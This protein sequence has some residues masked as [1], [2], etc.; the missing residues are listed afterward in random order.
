MK[1]IFSLGTVL[2]FFLLGASC[3]MPLNQPPSSS[4]LNPSKAE[5]QAVSTQPVD[6]PLED[7]AKLSSVMERLNTTLPYQQLIT[8]KV[9]IDA[10]AQKC[11]IDSPAGSAAQFTQITHVDEF[12]G[13]ECLR[14]TNTGSLYSV[15]EVK[16]GGLL[17]VFYRTHSYE[18][19]GTYTQILNWYYVEKA[20]SYQDFASISKGTAIEK[21]V[22]IDPVTR[23]FI[24]RAARTK[25]SED[26]F[27]YHYLKDGI[28]IVGY[29]YEDGVY[30]VVGK[31]FQDDYKIKTTRVSEKV[32]HH[33]G[34]ILPMDSI[35]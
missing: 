21:M 4:S 23:V 9:D 7:P 6:S 12:F 34:H 29:V 30:K 18:R 2:L 35:A 16:Q 14:K 20:L 1:R 33:D 3:I 27:S 13:V 32:E 31:H 5:S 19:T 17:Y 22:E 25:Q 8:K 15:H 24:D 28:L 26:M 11:N 10:F